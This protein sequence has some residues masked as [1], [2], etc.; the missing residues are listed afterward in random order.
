MAQNVNSSTFHP[1]PNR[2]ASSLSS[3]LIPSSSHTLNIT[4]V[5]HFL[6]HTHSTSS[7]FSSPNHLVAT[8][9]SFRDGLRVCCF[10]TNS[11]LGHIKTIRLFLDSCPY[12]HIIAITE[13]KLT[14]QQEDHLGS[15]G[16]YGLIEIDRVVV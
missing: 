10:N 11:L 13:I 9:E 12:N 3:T 2:A 15:L 8:T 16:V 4:S 5:N 1:H 6:P 14:A 7:P